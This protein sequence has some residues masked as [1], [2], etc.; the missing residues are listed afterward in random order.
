MESL[1]RVIV[2]LLAVA[3]LIRLVTDGWAGVGDWL[4]AKFLG[5]VS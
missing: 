4:R 2:G 3:L 1:A 5:E